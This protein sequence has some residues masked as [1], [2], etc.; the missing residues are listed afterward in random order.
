MKI[1]ELSPDFRLNYGVIVTKKQLGM[2][3]GNDVII[4]IFKN[5]EY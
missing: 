5:K 4:F 3:E 1:L 2:V